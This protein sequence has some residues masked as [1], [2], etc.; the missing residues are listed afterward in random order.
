M[1]TWLP[2]PNLR[3]SVHVLDSGT[4]GEQLANCFKILFVAARLRRGDN[5]RFHVC[6]RMW[7]D[8]HI[9]V[10]VLA[11]ACLREM[12]DR[13]HPPIVLSPR[14]AEGLKKYNMPKDWLD[15]PMVLPDWLGHERLHASHRATLKDRM[16]QWYAQFGWDEPAV[17]CLWWPG[18]MPI[19]GDWLISPSKE[20]CIVESFDEQRRPVALTKQGLVPIERKDVYLR[21]WQRVVRNDL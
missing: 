10:A 13:G 5:Y 19:V 7:R 3:L 20:I 2:Y 12:E 4:L 21:K 11:D 1:I 16:N 9:A 15:E 6:T 14:T 17:S 18:K 8:H